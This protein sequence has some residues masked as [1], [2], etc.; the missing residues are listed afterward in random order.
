MVAPTL[1]LISLEY[2]LQEEILTLPGFNPAVQYLAF[3]LLGK[4]SFYNLSTGLAEH[5]FYTKIN[6][7]IDEFRFH[8]LDTVFLNSPC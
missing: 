1:S 7:M 3:T 8:W 5:H 6:N 2:H 4:A